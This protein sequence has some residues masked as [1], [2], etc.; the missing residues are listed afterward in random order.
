VTFVDHPLSCTS[1]FF[2][3]YSYRGRW[4]I[5]C[6]SHRY[7]PHTL[8]KLSI[9]RVFRITQPILNFVFLLKTV[10]ELCLLTMFLCNFAYIPCHCLFYYFYFDRVISLGC[11]SNEGI[12]SPHWNLLARIG[13]LVR[14]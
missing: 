13:G 8:I 12:L 11:S 10:S 14:S 9:C 1:L 5:S 2:S 4:K 7:V 6:I 3:S